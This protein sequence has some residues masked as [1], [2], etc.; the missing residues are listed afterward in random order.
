MPRAIRILAL[1]LAL[2]GLLGISAAS[3]LPA[4]A[5]AHA[6]TPA[7]S[8]SICFAAHLTASEPVSPHIVCELKYRGRAAVPSSYFGYVPFCTRTSRT[9]GPPPLWL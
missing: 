3:A 2:F 1:V 4:H 7:N 5:H 9:R 8:C 6:N